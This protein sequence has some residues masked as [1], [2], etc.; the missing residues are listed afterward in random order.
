MFFACFKKNRIIFKINLQDS[1]A[2]KNCK[3]K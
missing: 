1:R 2:K 3:P